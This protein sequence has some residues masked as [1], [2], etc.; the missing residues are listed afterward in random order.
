MSEI[1]LAIV[2]GATCVAIFVVAMVSG[3]AAHRSQL[4][5]AVK[6]T[7]PVQECKELCR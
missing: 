2:L 4:D 3:Y 1:R 6:C 7:R 5:C